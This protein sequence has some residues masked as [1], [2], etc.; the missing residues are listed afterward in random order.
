MGQH[1]EDCQHTSSTACAST[2]QEFLSRARHAGIP[3]FLAHA[4]QMRYRAG[5]SGWSGLQPVQPLDI[6]CSSLVKVAKTVWTTH[7]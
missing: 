1:L 6:W 5:T 7:V 2:W 4:H 3:C